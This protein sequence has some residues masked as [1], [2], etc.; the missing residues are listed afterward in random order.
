MRLLNA[1]L[2]LALVA[3]LS[4]CT[5]ATQWQPQEWTTVSLEQAQAECHHEIQMGSSM[6][7]CM[8]SKGWR[9]VY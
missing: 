7:V 3:G 1:V 8:A 2:A 4:G 6:D 5:V 9:P